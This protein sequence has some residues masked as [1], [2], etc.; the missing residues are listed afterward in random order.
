MLGSLSGQCRDLKLVCV[1]VAVHP[2]KNGSKCAPFH[3]A[4][5]HLQAHFK[6]RNSLVRHLS[7]LL[8]LSLSPLSPACL[9]SVSG[10]KLGVASLV[11][12]WV[13]NMSEG[14]GGLGLDGLC[15][16][17]HL[18]MIIQLP[19]FRPGMGKIW[20]VGQVQPTEQCFPA[21][22]ESFGPASPGVEAAQA[23]V[24]VSEP[25]LLNMLL[26]SLHGDKS[27]NPALILPLHHSSPCYQDPCQAGGAGGCCVGIPG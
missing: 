8:R 6:P 9:G 16:R 24:Y 10:D 11:K 15:A 21:N 5:L 19:Q 3:S 7:V 17:V 2:G 4:Y 27:P 20:L 22:G 14:A 1:L 18:G 25:A 13:W 26:A 12:F 23:M